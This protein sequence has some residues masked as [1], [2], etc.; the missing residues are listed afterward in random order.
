MG[1]ARGMTM[2][3]LITR[4][5]MRPPRKSSIQRLRRIAE[6]IEMEES[7]LQRLYGDAGKASIRGSG[8]LDAK[9][10]RDILGY[11]EKAKI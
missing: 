11:L 5:S 3:N 10:I 9:A 1:G 4:E 8:R 7:R 2:R 6:R